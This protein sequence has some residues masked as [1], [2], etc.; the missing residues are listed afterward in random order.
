[1]HDLAEYI[2]D[3]LSE[4]AVHWPLPDNRRRSGEPVTIAFRWFGSFIPADGRSLLDHLA[5]V[6]RS[7]YRSSERMNASLVLYADDPAQADAE[8]VLAQVP[9]DDAPGF[10][11]EIHLA[12]GEGPLPGWFRSPAV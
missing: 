10:A 4:D 1:M 11:Y 6:L 9:Q 12:D 2:A 3:F 8:M 5:V 7:P